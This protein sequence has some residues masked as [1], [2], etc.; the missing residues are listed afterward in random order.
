MATAQNNP[1][2]LETFQ[3]GSSD[4]ALRF[5]YI[6]HCSLDAVEEKRAPRWPAAV[7][8]LSL[9][10]SN[11]AQPAVFV[12]VLQKTSG[13][14]VERVAALVCTMVLT[15]AAFPGRLLLPQVLLPRHEQAPLALGFGL[16]RHEPA[17]L[18][19]GFGL[20]NFGLPWLLVASRGPLG[21][22]KRLTSAF[23]GLR[24]LRC[25]G[26]RPASP[27]TPTLASCTPP[28]TT[29]CLGTG[30]LPAA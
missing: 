16:C 6:V 9:L 13:L 25:R 19:L 11:S 21:L 3:Q 23:A 14:C 5:H 4:D 2:Y 27:Q 1:L 8:L 20:C 26:R 18:A 17:P 7:T 28:R 24:Q 29:R 30:R 22:F 10:M 12:C 15:L